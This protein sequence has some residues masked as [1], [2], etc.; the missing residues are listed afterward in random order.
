[1]SQPL[2]KASEVT[3]NG[4]EFRVPGTKNPA[5][6]IIFR[7]GQQWRAYYNVCPH[8]NRS[9]NWAPDKFL[10]GDDGLL[11]CPHHGAAFELDSGKCLQGPCK[12]KSLQTCAIS[13]RE[14]TVWL[15]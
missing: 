5:Y 12:G 6:L 8:E 1:M 10:L 15:D 3:E 13:V 9:L 14:G 2:C 7:R 11:V 4:R